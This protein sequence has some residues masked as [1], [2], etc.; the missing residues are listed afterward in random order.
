MSPGV[1]ARNLNG[2]LLA[3]NCRGYISAQRDKQGV[4]ALLS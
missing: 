1:W 4:Q 2:W 3:F